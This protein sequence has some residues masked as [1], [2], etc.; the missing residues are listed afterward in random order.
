MF[1]FELNFINLVYTI[2]FLFSFFLSY[3]VIIYSRLEELFKKRS[4]WA[5]R[6]AQIIISLILAY[7]IA[8]ALISLINST[9]FN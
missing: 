8:T 9:Q 2:I 6:I 1:L 5:I 4:I 3:Y 7:F